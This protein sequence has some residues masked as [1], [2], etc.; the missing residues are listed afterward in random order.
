MTSFV[1]TG[2]NIDMGRLQSLV[3]LVGKHRLVLDLSCRKKEGKYFVVTD[4]WQK[5]TDMEVSC[6]LVIFFFEEM[7]FENNLFF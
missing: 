1:F 5:F 7:I 3:A 4:R 6:F 2:G